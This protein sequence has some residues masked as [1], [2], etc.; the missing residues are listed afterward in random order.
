MPARAV[1]PSPRYVTGPRSVPTPLTPAVVDLSAG[2]GAEG[3]LEE[4]WRGGTKHLGEEDSLLLVA[5]VAA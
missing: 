3:A 4:S 2:L 5:A 1:M